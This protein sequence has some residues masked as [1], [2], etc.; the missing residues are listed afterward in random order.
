M[1]LTTLLLAFL[2]AAI[3]RRNPDV[4]ET[5]L[6]ERVAEREATLAKTLAE[7]DEARASLESAWRTIDELR[8]AVA[9]LQAPYQAPY[10]NDP[11]HDPSHWHGALAGN[12]LQA[13]QFQNQ[14]LAAQNQQLAAQAAQNQFAAY[15]NYLGA[16]NLD[17]VRWL[18]CT[19]VPARHDVLI[20]RATISRASLSPG[21][22]VRR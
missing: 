18:D 4:E 7:R 13:F 12:Q 5:R 22:R 14:Q 16:Q 20:A 6:S 3:A 9:T 11:G 17:A 1:S 8:R 10:I 19:C 2:P 21:A 15:Q